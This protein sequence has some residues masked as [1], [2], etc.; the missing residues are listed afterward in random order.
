MRIDLKTFMIEEA[1]RFEVAPDAIRM[2]I[3]WGRYPNLKLSKDPTDRRCKVVS[4]KNYY[5]PLTGPY[6]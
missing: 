6:K 4:G 2:R 3:K 5:A 1:E